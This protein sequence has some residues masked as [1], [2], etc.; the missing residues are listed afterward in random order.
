MGSPTI[1]MGDFQKAILHI[2]RGYIPYNPIKPTIKPPKN[3]VFSFPWLS[4]GFSDVQ[5]PEAGVG[6]CPNFSHHPS[7]GGYN[8]SPINFLESDVQKP[9]PKWDIC[10][11]LKIR[12]PNDPQGWSYLVGNHL[13]GVS[14]CLSHTHWPNPERVPFWDHPRLRK[15]LDSFSTRNKLVLRL[16]KRRICW[17][18]VVTPIWRLW[19]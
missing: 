11:W 15:F 3:T 12:V 2:T 4:H 17:C 6:K 16:T 19:G 7:L 14:V 13:F 8:W 9:Q 1:S 5:L 18:R 10:Q